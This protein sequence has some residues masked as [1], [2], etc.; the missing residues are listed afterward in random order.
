MKVDKT[1]QII[2]RLED[3]C[4]VG[5]GRKDAN[6]ASDNGEYPFFTC[7]TNPLKSTTYSFDG[8]NLII[9]GN[10]DIGR[11]FYYNGKIEAYQ[12]TYVLHLKENSNIDI[13]YLYLVFRAGWKLFV[14]NKILGAAM[15]Y[16]KLG[17]LNSFP[18]PIY[19]IGVQQT[20]ATELDSIQEMIDGYKAQLTDLD[21]LAQSI[22]LDMFGSVA[23][24]DKSWDIIPMGKLGDFKNGL[25][26]NKGEKGKIFK[27][28]GVG[29]FQDL[30][31]LTLFD[32][33]PSIE[34]ESIS[35]EYLLKNEDIVFVRSNGNKN[36]VGRCL[37]V[38][39]NKEEVTFSGFCIRFRKSTDIINKYLVALLTD[40]GFKK[41][42]ILKSN[43]I[44]I[45][46]I[47]QKLLSN[48]P[49][50]VPPIDLQKQFAERVESIEQQKELIRQQLADAE[51]LMAERMQYY[52][53]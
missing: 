5:T 46:N 10:G 19:E 3:I 49:I 40:T 8:E 38:Y 53:S 37:E 34:L 33:I 27:I 16:I 21:A 28:I 44:G 22:F 11:C 4:I 18:V 20:I 52:F 35:S 23:I 43:G 2:C 29:D 6:H 12:R 7:G 48:L 15:P 30:K 32:N 42:H 50:P 25:N 1:K 26:Y 31:S 47:N 41:A 51:Q 9:P 36:L 13:K 39:P 45:Q 24:N 17:H 14:K